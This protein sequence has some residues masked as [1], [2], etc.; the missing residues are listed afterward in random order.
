MLR[1]EGFGSEHDLKK[2]WEHPDKECG[3][4]VEMSLGSSWLLQSQ[5]TL[6]GL[7]CS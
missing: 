1:G 5:H 3:L 2:N 4:A 7:A 6:N